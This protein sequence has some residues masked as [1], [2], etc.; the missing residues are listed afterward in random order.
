ML[1][2]FLGS[3]A[4]GRWRPVVAAAAAAAAV[5]VA[6]AAAAAAEAVLLVILVELAA[7]V[8]H[9][10]SCKWSIAVGG[11]FAAFI[12]PAA[13]IL[14][15]AIAPRCTVVLLPADVQ[16]PNAPHCIAVGVC[17]AAGGP[18]AS[19]HYPS[20]V[21]ARAVLLPWPRS[22]LPVLAFPADGSTPLSPLVP[23]CP[24][25]LVPVAVVLVGGLG[26][27]GGLVAWGAGKAGVQVVAA[28]VGLACPRLC[29]CREK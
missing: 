24:L 29:W 6:A 14:L 18:L 27:S 13:C 4:T 23:A 10:V 20:V 17:L 5:V 1:P 2:A 28:E 7:A 12:R 21:G 19:S 11:A 25:V 8:R 9:R 15:G 3:Q 16:R 22:V 26:A